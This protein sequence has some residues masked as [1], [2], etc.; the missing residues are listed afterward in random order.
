[1][2]AQKQR[3]FTL[4]EL[5]VTVTVIAILAAVGMV[6]YSGVQKNARISKRVQDLAAF[7]LALET[8]KGTTGYYPNVTAAQTFVCIESLTGVNTLTPNYMP[9]IP[10]DPSQSGTNNCYLYTSNGT[11]ATLAAT[12]YKLRTDAPATEMGSAEYRTQPNLIDPQRDGDTTTACAV[13]NTGSNTITAWAIYSP[14]G[15]IY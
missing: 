10:R 4:I 7:K 12:E 9:V 1:M 13:S 3:G 15:C 5:M 6:V 14:G 8:F 11:G 2:S